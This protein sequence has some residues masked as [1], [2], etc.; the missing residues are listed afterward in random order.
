MTRLKLFFVALFAMNLLNFDIV[1]AQYIQ[2]NRL[3][4][5]FYKYHS[6][7]RDPEL[8]FLLKLLRGGP[9]KPIGQKVATISR[10]LR[11]LSSILGENIRVEAIK[12]KKVKYIAHIDYNSLKFRL[13]VVNSRSSRV[14]DGLYYPKGLFERRNGIFELVLG[15]K[16]T[17]LVL[18]FLPMGKKY[19]IIMKYRQ[20]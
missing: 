9:S 7:S 18:K 15:S 1:H 2:E 14:I 6:V 20:F 12:R 10:N 16:A 17:N 8:E 3:R 11:F 13:W 4:R 5:H 19:Q